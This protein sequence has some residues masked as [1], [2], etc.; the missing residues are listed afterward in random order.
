MAPGADI[1]T[2]LLDELFIDGLPEEIPDVKAKNKTQ[3]LYGLQVP[4]GGMFNHNHRSRTSNLYQANA[5][6][7]DERSDQ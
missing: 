6:T 1:G 3:I 7:R 4:G 2:A 5:L